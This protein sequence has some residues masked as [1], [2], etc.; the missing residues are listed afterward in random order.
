[1]LQKVKLV[2]I[3]EV[4]TVINSG[5]KRITYVKFNSLSILDMYYAKE[6]E[7]KGL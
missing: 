7:V 1:M 5:V 2:T 3:I 6:I 4:G